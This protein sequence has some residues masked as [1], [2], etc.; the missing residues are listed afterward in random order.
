MRKEWTGALVGKNEW[1][2]KSPQL[3]PLKVGS[4]PQAIRDPRP[5]RTEPAVEVLLEFNPFISGNSG[6][7]VITVIEPGHGRSTGDTV[8]FRGAADFDGFT[9]AAVEDEDGFSI[10]EINSDRYTFDISSG[11]SSETATSGNVRG[12]GPTA[13]AGPVT[14]SA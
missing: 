5:D 6:S 11:G 14:V 13:S 12:G 4:D 7:S 9:E 3:L 1:E 10:T 8:R 2:K